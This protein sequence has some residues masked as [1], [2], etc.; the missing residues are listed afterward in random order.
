MVFSVEGQQKTYKKF[1]DTV[2]VV[3]DVILAPSILF[4]LGKCEILP[5]SKDSINVIATFI[6]SHPK[7]KIEI[8][9]HT[10]IRGDKRKNLTLSECRASSILNCLTKDLYAPVTNLVIKGYGSSQPIFTETRITHETEKKHLDL[11]EREVFYANNKRVEI[12]ILKV[13]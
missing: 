6:K 11:S 4:E 12:K 3:N 5:L 8:G 1:N 7:L 13:E 9:V 10:D 2:F